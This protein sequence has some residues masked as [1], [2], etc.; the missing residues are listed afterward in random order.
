MRYID[1]LPNNVRVIENTWIEMD[2]GVHLAAKLWLPE[3]AE[4]QPVPA[5]LEYIPYR[6]RDNTRRRDSMIQTYMA[7][8]GYAV[9][10]VDMRGSGDSEGVL[11]DEYIRREQDDGLNVLAWMAEQPWCD[12]NIGM[13]GISWGGFN[14]LQIAAL[15]PPQLKAVISVCSTDDRYADDVHY[16]GGCL[17]GDN[18]SW[19]STMFAYNSCPPDPKIV[20]EA[21]RELWLQRLEGS[22]LWVANWLEHQR[23]DEFWKHGS[24][25]EHWSAIQVPVLAVSGWADGYSNAVF[26]LL[27]NLQSPCRAL[28]GPWSHKYPHVG[29]PGPAIGW[30]QECRRW[31]DHWLR[32]EDNGV[33]DDPGLRA[34]M[35]DSTPPN[36]SYD[37]RPG[38]WVAEPGWPSQNVSMQPYTLAALR[39]VPE[40]PDQAD[41]E[42]LDERPLTIESPLRTGLFSGKWCSYSAPP[43]LPS[44]QRQDD[45]GA[46]T[47]DSPELEAPL[48]ILGSPEV[49]L[50]LEANR[51]VAMVAVRLSDVRPDGSIT[52]VTYGLLNL[53]HRDSHEEPSPLE[54]GKR[55]RVRVRMN[56]VAQRF[57]AGHSIR[58]AV[59]SVYWPLAWPA[60]ELVQLTVHPRT[61]TLRLP[62]RAPRPEDDTL[63]PFEAPESAR[64]AETVQVTPPDQGWQVTHDLANGRDELQVL[65]D[66]GR[67]YHPEIDLA[68]EDAVVE[69][70]SAVD[71]DLASLK[72]ETITHKLFE[73]GEWRVSIRTRTVLTSTKTEL[74]IHADLDAYEGDQR[75][76][77]HSWDRRVPRDHL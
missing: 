38:R 18:L 27:A 19:A 64:P 70:Y 69:R 24:V 34:Y 58:L 20:G 56:D 43:D 52:R 28:V 23:R 76:F 51:P 42:E 36:T 14:G 5:I 75:V 10:R 11:V 59:S 9:A 57:P 62:V 12:G 3:A 44:D 73:R 53:T 32:G 71:N 47:F 46:L 22:G 7:G 8:H 13:I 37:T 17:L 68:H 61:S 48:E 54:P 30:L 55:Y 6:K 49:E 74:V 40:E 67:V 25:C 29:Q 77:C 2:D 41:D 65:K 63:R 1:E 21:W 50:D 4:D 45:G 39:M 72:G 26:R 31:W 15:R 35:Q 16:M 60:P 66:G 33:P